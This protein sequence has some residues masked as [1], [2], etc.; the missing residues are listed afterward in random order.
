MVRYQT[1]KCSSRRNLCPKLVCQI[2]CQNLWRLFA[3]LR[4]SRESNSCPFVVTKFDIKYNFTLG[5][6]SPLCLGSSMK[7]LLNTRLVVVGMLLASLPFTGEAKSYSSGGGKS[8]SSSSSH[9]SSSGSRSGGSSSG[10]RNS[11]S[12]SSRSSSPP[13]SKSSPSGG[14][15]SRPSY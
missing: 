10:T 5:R 8:Y 9:S 4:Y 12:S 7:V 13:A 1:S 2:C 14:S 6:Q 11:G 15:S 3:P